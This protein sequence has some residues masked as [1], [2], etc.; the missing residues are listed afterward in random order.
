LFHRRSYAIAADKASQQV[1][2]PPW[3]PVCKKLIRRSEKI[4][5]AIP[6]R[7]PNNPPP[8]RFPM[9]MRRRLPVDSGKSYLYLTGSC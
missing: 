1:A 9:Y 2:A 8:P 4:L 5:S 6:L 3:S 7:F